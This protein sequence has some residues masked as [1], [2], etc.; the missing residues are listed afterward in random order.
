MRYG[1]PEDGP[2]DK[3][4]K[5]QEA[6]QTPGQQEARKVRILRSRRHPGAGIVDFAPGR[7]GAARIAFVTGAKTG[8]CLRTGRGIATPRGETAIERLRPGDLVVTRDNGIQP[9]KG[10]RMRRFSRR[11]FEA[12]PHLWPV[13]IERGALGD[14]LPE[15]AML[16]TPNQR[17]LAPLTLTPFGTRESGRDGMVAAKHLIDNRSIHPVRLMGLMHVHLEFE[18]TQVVLSNGVWTECFQP[19]DPQMGAAGNAQRNEVL[20][21]YPELREEI[22]AARA[23]PAARRAGDAPTGADPRHMICV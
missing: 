8:P 9:L 3:S 11:M 21:L 16:V 6:G 18:H 7:K 22:R 14:G 10:I 15:R 5:R 12:N 20:E 4:V 2:H 17:L 13:L 23:K 19:H 1:R